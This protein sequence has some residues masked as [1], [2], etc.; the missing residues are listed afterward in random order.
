MMPSSP[1]GVYKSLVLAIFSTIAN[2]INASLIDAPAPRPEVQ[3]L[4]YLNALT[5]TSLHFCVQ[6]LQATLSE[7]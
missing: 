2:P 3:F 1:F 4:F 6:I 7:G 5:H